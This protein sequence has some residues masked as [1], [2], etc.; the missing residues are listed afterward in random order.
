M[1]EIVIAVIVAFAMFIQGATGFGSALVT[2][3][4]LIQFLGL[5]VATPL[6]ALV[7]QSAV[8]VMLLRYR[9]HWHLRSIWRILAASLAAIPLSIMLAES[10]DSHL[11][12]VILG[13]IMIAYALY[14]LFGPHIPYIKDE[15][16]GFVFG[17][18]NG[19]LHGAY[20]TGGPPL[21]IYGNARRWNPGEFK[22]NLQSIFFINGLLVVATH[23]LKG[24]VTPEVLHYYA[25]MMP[26]VLVGLF[27]GFRLDSYIQ[28][29]TFRRAVLIL[30]IILGVSLV[31]K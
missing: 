9:E 18:A 27:L 29:E 3:P 10:V 16:W 23:W 7:G 22:G 31:L 2:M 24:N 13:L 19:L 11:A 26:G 8:I 21:V 15:R 5:Q 28:P 30:L 25:V 4:F 17:F 6:F 1:T 12:M 14:G 20:N